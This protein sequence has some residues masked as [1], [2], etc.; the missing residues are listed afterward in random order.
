MTRII[1]LTGGIG[2]GKSAVARMLSELGAVVIDTDRLGHEAM[3]SGTEVWRGVV[4][5]FGRQVIGSDG[6]I[7]RKALGKIVFANAEA[8][9]RLNQIMHPRIYEMTIAK[10]EEC[11][12]EG[13]RVVVLE[14]PLLIEA[15]WTHLVDEVWV[16]AAP[17]SKVIERLEKERGL[18]RKE[19]LARIRS[20]LPPEERLKHAGAVIDNEGSL[21]ELKA[22]VTALWQKL[23]PV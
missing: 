15:G 18:D 9:S 23:T 14:A 19:T 22:R 8:L 1:G 12:R 11:R 16:T 4:A 3:R 10:I 17:E 21:Q 7:D 6:E 20:Q 5:A 2:T 13:V